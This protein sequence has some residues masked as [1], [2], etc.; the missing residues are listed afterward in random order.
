LI[1]E[2]AGPQATLS[3]AARFG[4]FAERWA[5]SKTWRRKLGLPLTARSLSAWLKRQ[6]ADWNTSPE[7]KQ[8]SQLV[9]SFFYLKTAEPDLDLDLIKP[10]GVGGGEVILNSRMLLEEISEGLRFVGLTGCRG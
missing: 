8:R 5:A 3:T 9:D 10:R 4:G 2:G 7:K 6:R 1:R